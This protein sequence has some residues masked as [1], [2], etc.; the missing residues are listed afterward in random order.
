MTIP[1]MLCVAVLA[2][3]T[4]PAAAYAQTASPSA[5]STPST[6]APAATPVQPAAPA[7]TGA[8]AAAVNQRIATLK[9]QLG[10]TAAE[11]PLWDSFAAVMHDNAAQT[12]AL[13][14]ERASNAARMSAVENM[15]SYAEIARSYADSTQ[16]LA[17]AFDSLYLGLSDAQRQKADAL[18]RA[19]A[20][21]APEPQRR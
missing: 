14:A 16:R 19:Q 7:L 17:T 15:N 12:Q 9:S 20:T 5:T 1:A 11:L 21:T 4:I 2:A 3:L 18:F 6:S 13:F 8:T 10:I